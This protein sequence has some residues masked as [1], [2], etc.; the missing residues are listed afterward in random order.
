MASYDLGIKYYD[1]TLKESS[2]VGVFWTYIASA[3]ANNTRYYPGDYVANAAANKL[4]QT[5]LGGTTSGTE[6]V[7]T[8]GTSSSTDG[9]AWLYIGALSTNYSATTFTAGDY[10]KNS[11]KVYLARNTAL[12]LNTVAPTHTVG[13]RND[14]AANVDQDT[15]G[16]GF[17][18]PL[19]V[20]KQ[21]Y[22]P[23]TL[24]TSTR[25]EK[26]NMRW[27]AVL[28]ELAITQNPYALVDV[29]SNS[30]RG[31]DNG[32][33]I[34]FTVAYT[35]TDG[36]RVED[37]TSPGTYI[38]T[39]TLVIKRWIATA[40]FRDL[41]QIRQVYDPTRVGGDVYPTNPDTIVSVTA[42]KVD[43]SGSYTV[44]TV[45]NHITVTEVVS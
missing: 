1:V 38:T 17:V 19:A 25:K 20:V 5:I 43:P 21:A 7:H 12:A 8:S 10:V 26:E 41:T 13:T 3:Y 31:D 36:M 45:E 33:I 24:T 40:L 28:R 11:S 9:V 35:N 30:L 6:P 34:T 27:E 42:E 4:Y 16:N 39:P 14:G 22:F 23:T 15:T 18:D 44:V 32:S 2:A 29:Q 37:V